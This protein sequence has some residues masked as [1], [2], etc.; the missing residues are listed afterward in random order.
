ML[1]D[2]HAHVATTSPAPDRQAHSARALER[3]QHEQREE[4]AR[5]ARIEEATPPAATIEGQLQRW[6]DAK[7]DVVELEP[8]WNGT[9]GRQGKPLTSGDG[10]HSPQAPGASYGVTR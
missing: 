9:M 7:A 8:T 1:I 6:R 2:Y 10:L 3:L 5:L 4:A